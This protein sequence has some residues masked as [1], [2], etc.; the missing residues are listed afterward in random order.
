MTACPG[1]TRHWF[2]LRASVCGGTG[3][4]TPKCVRCG[5]PNPTE[6]TTDD[7]RTVLEYA[8]DMLDDP[9]GTRE[10]LDNLKDDVA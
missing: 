4:R 6:L 1:H 5:A 7:W 2:S 3:C 9:E 8:P 10:W